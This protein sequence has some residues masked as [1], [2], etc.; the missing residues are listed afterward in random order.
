MTDEMAAVYLRILELALLRIRALAGMGRSA[1]C[2]IEVNH[3]HNLP[4]VLLS[5]DPRKEQYYW[6]VERPAYMQQTPPDARTG[7]E[8][9]WDELAGLRGGAPAGGGGEGAT[10]EDES[11]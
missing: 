5:T 6:D 7:F 4:S 11:T 10:G 8:D 2:G 3:V 9:L 1:E